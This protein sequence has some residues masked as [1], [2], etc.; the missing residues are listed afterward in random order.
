MSELLKFILEKLLGEKNFEIE[1]VPENDNFV[2]FTAHIQ[3]KDMGL[4]I[5]KEGAT[6][7]SIRNILRIKA[8]LNKKAFTL[9]VV[10]KAS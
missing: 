7:K 8:I 3:A 10:E 5:G 4:I 1:E 2:R 9:N 6:I